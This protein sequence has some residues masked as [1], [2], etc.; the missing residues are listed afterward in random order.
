M[1]ASGLYRWAGYAGVVGAI[2]LVLGQW[3]H[4][5]VLASNPGRWELAH[6][7]LFVSIILAI[8]GLF[9]I[10]TRQTRETGAL[11]FV[12]FVLI[13][14]ALMGFSGIVWLE[15]FVSPAL[16]GDAAARAAL[17]KLESGQ[18]PSLIGPVLIASGAA[19][20]IGSLLF[21]W[22]TARAGVFSRTAASVTLVGGFVFGLSP[23][24]FASAPALDKLAATVF[25]V[26]F[27]WLAYGLT[28]ERRMMIAERMA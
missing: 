4:P 26:G 3:L 5:Q 14:I 8:P 20:S 16:A 23:L 7:I 27:A 17:E 1:G 25:G 13:F 6:E 19:F 9:G 10:Y 12:G 18:T 28:A 21:G 11:G 24:L 2:L 22:A 15:A